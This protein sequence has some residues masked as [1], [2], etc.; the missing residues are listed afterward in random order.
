[1]IDSLTTRSAPSRVAI[2]G[3]GLLGRLT[4]W[5]LSRAGIHV[6]V[7][8][9][10]SLDAPTA[11]ATSAAGMLSPL[12][13]AVVSDYQIYRMGLHSL[14]LWPQWLSELG[15]QALTHFHC[16]GSLVV[17]HPQD[18]C[19]LVQ[20][21]ADLTRL[22]G[23]NN[24][25]MQSLNASQIQTVEPDLN[26]QFKRA[27]LLE[28]EAHL[29]NRQLLQTLL[30]YLRHSD[31][32]TLTDNTPVAVA[33]H[34]I[35]QLNRQQKTAYDWVIDCRGFGAKT[36]Q[37]SLRGVRGET[38]HVYTSEV[39]LQRPVRL[40]HPRYQLYI[41]PKPNQRYIIG[42]TQIESEDTSPISLQSSLEL[43]SA[44]YTLAPAF[45]ES[46][47]VESDSN[48]RPAYIDNLPKITR[49]DG[50]ICANGLYRHGYLLAPVMVELLLTTFNL[51]TS[52]DEFSSLIQ[53]SH[54]TP[55]AQ[56]VSL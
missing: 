31:K 51:P 23:R 50:L 9:A 28:N 27:L 35:T 48:L 22:I 44:L 29:D 25:A 45:A 37:P 47:I 49:D 43:S 55:L 21:E 16:N 11:A 41:V 2:A 33:P 6:D 40:M 1:M 19:E 12:S 15:P 14:T 38:L 39:N 13:E 10:G 46:R 36:Q 56:K 52:S 8:E 34:T 18:D 3:A 54:A 7:Y 53:H 20:F 24:I 26:P 30:E 42:A 5:R 32:V 4:A 17:A